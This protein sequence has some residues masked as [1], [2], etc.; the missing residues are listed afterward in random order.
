VAF[1]LAWFAIALIPTSSFFP[2]AEVLNEHRI[3]FPC[4]GLAL[5][6]VYGA[7]LAPYAGLPL[8]FAPIVSLS[9]RPSSTSGSPTE[10]SERG[11]RPRNTSGWRSA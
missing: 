2:L 5:A 9:S 6:V 3:F 4:T 10:R 7:S 1:G 8:D 11:S